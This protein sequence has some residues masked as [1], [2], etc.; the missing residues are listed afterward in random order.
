MA[1]GI[2]RTR[3]NSSR[4]VRLLAELATAEAADGAELAE[5]TLTFAERLGLWLDWTDAIALS[6]A[7]DRGAAA[8]GAGARSG[9]QPDASAIA[10]EVDRVRAD[11]S[12]AIVTDPV[13]AA[14]GPGSAMPVAAVATVA[15]AAGA[16]DFAPYRRS[17][18]AHQRAMEARVGQLRARVRT[19]L[20]GLSPALGRVAALD[21]ALDQALAARERHLLSTVLVMLERHG[22]RLRRAQSVAVA[23]DGGP[24]P[25]RADL[26]VAPAGWP[27][28][29]GTDMQAVLLAELELRL[30]PVEGMVEAYRNEATRRQ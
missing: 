20:S 4:L 29:V 5:S 25:G 15:A 1:P 27:A 11:L 24:R 6:A 19:A 18:L 7:L 13:F 23:V 12:R 16:V 9:A 3:F 21:A 2:A 28:R 14:G 22:E 10:S 17:G 8:A 30:Q 26:A